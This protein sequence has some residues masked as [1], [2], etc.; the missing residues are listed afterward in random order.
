VELPHTGT[1]VTWS[2]T[3]YAV[4]AT[5]PQEPPYALGIVKLDGATSGLVHILGGVEPE[6]LEKGMRMEAVFQEERT[7]SYLDIRYFR[8]LTQG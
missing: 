2:V 3:R 7:G 5:Q 4:P 8:P 1:L 6:Q